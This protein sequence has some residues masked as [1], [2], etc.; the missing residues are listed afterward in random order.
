MHDTNLTSATCVGGKMKPSDGGGRREGRGGGGRLEGRG[1]GGKKKN[2]KRKPIIL[3]SAIII[4]YTQKEQFVTDYID[5]LNHQQKKAQNP[6]LRN[7]RTIDDQMDYLQRTFPEKCPTIDDYTMEYC[8]SS[9]YSV[10]SIYHSDDSDESEKPVVEPVKPKEPKK[11]VK[12]GGGRKPSPSF[13]PTIPVSSAYKVNRGALEDYYI[14]KV[15][16]IT[17]EVWVGKVKKRPTNSMS[18]IQKGEMVVVLKDNVWLH[19]EDLEK[20]E[21]ENDTTP[22][23]ARLRIGSWNVRCTGEFQSTE[24]FFIKLLQR[25]GRLAMCIIKSEC[26]IVALQEFPKSFK[27]ASGKDMTIDTHVLLPQLITK[28]NENSDDEMW[29]FGYTEDFPQSVWGSHRVVKKYPGEEVKKYSEKK[30]QYV[31]AFVYKMS[32]IDMHSVEQVI[33]LKFQ[34]NRFKHAPCLGRFTFLKKFHFSLCNVHLRPEKTDKKTKQKTDSRFEIEDLGK[35]IDQLKKYNPESTIILGDLNMSA[36]KYAPESALPNMRTTF[37]PYVDGVW[38]SFTEKKYFPAV[39]N[40]YT[41]IS[42]TQQYDNIWLPEDLRTKVDIPLEH[43]KPPNKAEYGQ[44]TNVIRLQEVFT[45]TDNRTMVTN[46]LT[47]HHLVYVDL[48]MTLPQKTPPLIKKVVEIDSHIVMEVERSLPIREYDGFDSELMMTA[49][50]PVAQPVD[51][52]VEELAIRLGQVE[53]NPVP[54]PVPVIR[55]EPVLSDPHTPPKE[56]KEPIA[57]SPLKISRRHLQIFFG[58]DKKNYLAE[59][60]RANGGYEHWTTNFLPQNLTPQEDKELQ[61]AYVKLMELQKE[62]FDTKKRISEIDD[63]MKTATGK[64]KKTLNKE[65]NRLRKRKKENE[66]EVKT[67]KNEFFPDLRF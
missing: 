52:Q 30:G 31:Q 47:E 1:G 55:G 21:E 64:T 57:P 40:R 50:E 13:S 56:P 27:T 22:I 23:E 62:Y 58:G 6:I 3:A 43:V 65:Y 14:T 8:S 54:V 46:E 2:K 25:F 15:S 39:I 60:I 66:E 37:P 59:K 7:F 12:P 42:E 38:K 61:K 51:E 67:I 24:E 44:S 5:R 41:N 45:G 26:D 48:K 33:D 35:C 28:L 18:T 9:D 49:P 20:D 11:P 17:S 29:G 16:E 10:Y 32:K 36:T 63:E 34:E 19:E 53:V 4:D